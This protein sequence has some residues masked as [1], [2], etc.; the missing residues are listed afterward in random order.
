MR[1][2]NNWSWEINKS[3][4]FSHTIEF[5]PDIATAL[6]IIDTHTIDLEKKRQIAETLGL[7]QKKEFHF[8][9]I[10]SATGKLILE[11]IAH[12]PHDHQSK[13]LEKIRE[14]CTSF[15]WKIQ[16]QDDF[17]YLKKNYNDP[18]P[19]N[20]TLTIP[21]VRTTIIQMIEIAEIDNFY[22]QLNI[23]LWQHF[24]TPL[25]HITLYSTSTRIDKQLRWIGIYSREQFDELY[26]KKI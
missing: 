24:I 3:A 8:T 25:P 9:I 13:I 16:L 12:F 6:L 17:Y 23:L 21:E 18:D 7:F 20:N 26:P 4:I 11:S 10:G 1:T 15:N 22:H 19:N 14:L 5:N 2:N